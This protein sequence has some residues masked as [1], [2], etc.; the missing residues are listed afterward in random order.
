MH[1]LQRSGLAALLLACALPA[2]G[3][4]Q[5]PLPAGASLGTVGDREG[6]ASIRRADEERWEL[7]G[8][9]SGLQPGDWLK[10]ATRGAN[11]LLLRFGRGEV[12]LGPGAMVE[13]KGMGE[14]KLL[15][16]EIKLAP[17]K[18]ETWRVH[19][20]KEN[21][22]LAFSERG[23]ARALGE[24][25]TRLER[26]PKWLTSYEGNASSEAMG[27]LL[28]K[29]DGR[30][31][32]L[33]MGYH[34]V[35][36]DIRDQIARTVVEESF[37]NHTSSILEGV[38][39]FP[40]PADASISGFSMW[41]GDE[42]VH[43]EIVE[44]QRARAIYETILREKRD[45]GLLEWAGGNVFKAR[46]YPIGHEKRIKISYTQ[47]LPKQGESYRYHY[48][49][50]SEMLRQHPLSK[51]ELSATI[52]SSETLTKV[53]SPSHPGRLQT[54]PKA[55]RFEFSAEETTP[56]RD[57]ELVV[58]T[59]PQEGGRATFIPHQR[60]EDGYFLCLVDAPPAPKRTGPAAP[61]DLIVIADTSGSVEGPARE[62]L[63]G[64]CEALLG[65][66]GPQD[67]FNLLT[68]DTE[69][70]WAFAGPQVP[71]REAIEGA[72]SHV[73]G[74]EPLGWSDLD[75]AFADA[76]KRAQP[77]THIVY[78]GDA[79]NTTGDADP[80]AFAQ[81]AAK[82][83]ASA[84]GRGSVH[85]V[86]PGP[87]GESQA[88]NALARLGAGSA[89]SLGEG[90]PALAAQGLID[91]LSAPKLS[92]LSVNFEGIAVAAL[93]PRQL[94]NLP[95]GG[96]Q[97]L[98]GRFLPSPGQ[99]LTAKVSVS[100]K[101]AG[102][103]FARTTE[104][105]FTT[106]PGDGNSFVPRL[107]ARLHLDALM[108]EGRSAETKKRVIELSEDFQI[109]TPYTSF[110]VLESDEDRER[111][112]VQKRFR[113]RD[114]EGFF[115]QGRSDANY[116]L[117]QKALLEAKRWRLHL[118]AR[119]LER[120]EAM[121]RTLIDLLRP[122]NAS[123]LN[124]AAQGEVLQVADARGAVG[125]SQ[126]AA[127]GAKEGLTRSLSARPGG[128]ADGALS[129]EAAGEPMPADA[130]EREESNSFD[131]DSSD[132]PSPSAA[133]MS[134]PM[135]RQAEFAEKKAERM[136]MALGKSKRSRQVMGGRAPARSN[137]LRGYIGVPGGMS[138]ADAADL[139]RLGFLPVE[140]APPRLTPWAGFLNLFPQVPAR[141][142][143]PSPIQPSWPDEVKQ[144]LFALDR[145]A[146]LARQTNSLQLTIARSRTDQRGRVH[147]GGEGRAVLGPEGWAQ[148]SAHVE[149]DDAAISWA[150]KSGEAL[151]RG[152]LG[153]LWRT[154]ST[155]PAKAE[156][157]ADF[158][159][160]LPWL[161][162][163]HV[164]HYADYEAEIT[165]REPQLV[166]IRMTP[167]AAQRRWGAEVE[168]DLDPTRGLVLAT[169]TLRRGKLL[170]RV[171]YGGFTTL[172]GQVWPTSETHFDE[173]ET[174]TWVT[175]WTL[176]E[177]P[178]AAAAAAR[179]ALVAPRAEGTVVGPLPGLIEARQA[180]ASGKPRFEDR[181]VALALELGEQRWDDAEP[182]VKALLAEVGAAPAQV[183]FQATWLTQ[184][185]RLE[186][187][188]TLIYSEA[189]AL[190]ETPR[191]AEVAR[192]QHLISWSHSL[193]AAELL[194]VLERLRAV[195]ARQTT[196]IDAAYPL[197]SQI[198]Q[199]LDRV[200]RGEDAFGLRRALSERFP[201]VIDAQLQYANQLYARRQLDSALAH[202][203]LRLKDGGPWLPSEA[204]QLRETI[205]NLLWTAVRYRPLI[206]RVKAWDAENLDPPLARH[207][208]ERLL[209]ALIMLDRE[210]EA[211][212]VIASWLA[213]LPADG[214][215]G[216]AATW[217]RAQAAIYHLLGRVPGLYYAD[218]RI[219]RERQAILQTVASR[220]LGAEQAQGPDQHQNPWDLGQEILYDWRFRQHASSSDLVTGL[221]NELAGGL[222]TLPA[223]RLGRLCDWLRGLGY[224]PA[225]NREAQ[226]GLPAAGWP[227]T[228]AAIYARWEQTPAGPDA[229]QLERLIL[230][231]GT[232]DQQLACHR[233][234][235]ELAKT[236]AERRA[237]GA[238]LL[239]A[240]L[241]AAWTA[242][243]EAEVR[244]LFLAQAPDEELKPEALAEARNAWIA[245][246]HDLHTWLI[247]S[248]VEA[249]FQ[250]LPERAQLDRRQVKSRRDALT[251][252]A[253]V[254]LR[255][256]L[257]ADAEG[258]PELLRPWFQIEA[259]WLGAKT[260]QDTGELLS[261]ARALLKTAVAG[262]A[263]VK[264]SPARD[265]R[266]RIL[267]SRAVATQL[268]LL[269]DLPREGELA[270]EAGQALETLINQAMEKKNQLLDWREVLYCYLTVV[271]GDETLRKRLAEWFG[272]GK[273]VKERRWG[274][275]L[276]A[277]LVERDGLAEA[278]AI[279]RKLEDELDHEEWRR[280][281][282]YYTAL[283][284][285]EDARWAK[286]QSWNHL[287]EWRLQQGLQQDFYQR[288]QRRGDRVPETLD[289]EIPL[290]FL[291]VLR[292]STSPQNHVWVLRNYYETTRDFRLLAC[293]PEAALGQSAQGIYQL[294]A[295]FRQVSTL[296]Q[297]EA[298]L[299]QLT[300]HL[301]VL[302]GRAKTVTDRRALDLIDF[303]SALQAARQR[304]GG[305]TSGE[306][307]LAAL[308][309]AYERASWAEGEA[310][311]YAEFL[312]QQGQLSPPALATEQLRQL[313][314]ILAKAD[315]GT[316]LHVALSLN[317]AQTEWNYHQQDAALRTLEACLNGVRPK[318]GAL[319]AFAWSVFETR[320]G[321]L[322]ARRAFREGEQNLIAER[323]RPA[324]ANMANMFEQRLATLYQNCLRAGGEVS[325]GSEE[326]LYR[327]LLTR[328][329]ERLGEAF[330]ENEAYQRLSEITNLLSIRASYRQGRSL[331]GAQRSAAAREVR[332]DA[333]DLA[334]TRLPALLDRFHHRGSPN[335]ISQ[336]SNV[337]EQVAGHLE[338]LSFQ[339]QRAENERRWLRLCRWDAWSNRGYQLI[340]LRY[341][342]DREGA[343]VYKTDLGRR[344][345]A[346]T[347]V[348]L[349][350]FLRDGEQQHQGIYYQNNGH[351]WHAARG[352]FL[353]K[354][355]QIAKDYGERD[356]VLERVCHYLWSGLHERERATALLAER[357]AAGQL[358]RSGRLTLGS[359]LLEL[360]RHAAGIPVFTKLVAERPTEVGSWLN[361]VR[362]YHHTGQAQ[363]ADAA[364]A[365]AIKELKAAEAWGE[366][367]MV[368]VGRVCLE[369]GRYELA[370]EL[371]EDGIKI[372]T[373]GRSD[374]GVGDG[375]LGTYY[376][377]LASARAQMGD[378]IGA[379]D[380]A[381]GAIVA[382]GHHRQQRQELLQV[383][384][385][386]LA[387]A[388]DLAA[389]IKHLD[390]EVAETGLE[391]PLL[392]RTLGDVLCERKDYVGA[393]VQLRLALEAQE[394]DEETHRLAIRCYDAQGNARAAAEQLLAL[395]RVL[396]HEPKV[397]VELGDRFARAKDAAA[398]ERAYTNLV[399]QQP[400]EAAA[401]G[402][403]AEVRERQGRFSDAATHWSQVVRVRSDEPQGYIGL[404]RALL[405]A[406]RSAAEPL[407]ALRTRE[408]EERFDAQVKEALRELELLGRQKSKK[409]F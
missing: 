373:R 247:E 228:L 206:E 390:A 191:Q 300:K 279:L 189:A 136:D 407:E 21:S 50:R 9:R 324:D 365:R 276:A 57:F 151:E 84:G 174:K 264:G 31:V 23:V 184:R 120:L 219:T 185:R 204:A 359:F 402:A 35:Q 361:L 56:E 317:L 69:V 310:R 54:T 368:Q 320:L 284:Q 254:A 211:D 179:A 378:T 351:F 222:S 237:R 405:R 305:E 55:A 67:R 406:G 260:K 208:H 371:L 249:E 364:L 217:S 96:Q 295:G 30:E 71:G 241:G 232:E 105:S 126:F 316:E 53:S 400:N 396:G 2:L 99:A 154:G 15:R 17:A 40:L 346:L 329:Y 235:L 335:M 43:G 212:E 388:K 149:G 393:L 259:I 193:G 73:E 398:A 221:W 13:L 5:G 348:G 312:A 205:G 298:T 130:L 75:P 337:V 37:V 6:S 157:L 263:A 178:P 24:A 143:E 251:S 111:F 277:V 340:N 47:V 322:E 60:A 203:D 79:A 164:R 44:K 153:L 230:S 7:A 408:W 389:Y 236:P 287:D 333:L 328:G 183:L 200:G 301:E 207:H 196:R 116:A 66:L 45:P 91:E 201:F 307:A 141:A 311:Y 173:R 330:D 268:L 8:E 392:R 255:A 87:Q 403:L 166:T 78:V 242:E 334:Y 385:E 137:E 245:Q 3:Q 394:T 70:R 139:A 323:A 18:G 336:V 58:Q 38:F 59:A 41:I 218:G 357:D 108:S 248:R 133:P 159:A 124:L 198:A 227:P 125:N 83:H 315:P 314:A 239:G 363:Q 148:L 353:A 119:T 169:R 81:R 171:E 291:A 215:S 338:A 214:L 360:K 354:S 115:A 344:L 234:L 356:E 252:G 318:G 302:R 372:H 216:D 224:T 63:I 103:P 89:R 32:A 262:V 289:E 128:E 223:E 195:A 28:A 229:S 129:D 82:L 272:D 181:L 160:L 11:A 122:G 294:A 186:E 225:E 150:M 380:A 285:R 112:K 92:E 98:I 147:P 384:R 46:V 278:A 19:G 95:L 39:Y 86:Q 93:Y 20:P 165:L 194:V 243:R 65:S 339:V 102:Q 202:L 90:D 325:L 113:M 209:A 180:V 158:P 313:R 308:R 270:K 36:V 177:L 74:R 342:A 240:L 106:T 321:Y 343:N 386:I 163:D 381:A 404:A 345:L 362:C 51:L 138:G 22:S 275:A 401:Q 167:P 256:R 49:L 187:L 88:I 134:P 142:S 42:Q 347:L 304:Q 176:G 288:Y 64:F 370:A 110:L 146:A 100:A 274:R 161:L 155:R 286:V 409:D 123:Q 303:L 52:S 226:D 213:A 399:E 383:L 135:E 4:E 34:K 250:A 379:V 257:L 197:E 172:L 29:V 376:R 341:E 97:V 296:L 355:L 62:A 326:Q 199:T 132:L 77:N 309:S 327:A 12:T 104:T 269:A 292:K 349:E 162:A 395:A 175:T 80:V 94:P 1:G 265:L 231:Y 290:R 281:A 190:A 283:D 280:L 358:G 152:V 16:G 244:R 233:R 332:P 246:L 210:A 114:G 271:E 182:A 297:E 68:V 131:K 366:G 109:M 140:D 261:A 299:D 144:L 121:N 273:E 319:P 25:L 382:W 352:D 377:D 72:L 145:R 267:A 48:A 306:R 369:T 238:Q 156:D 61:I 391:N 253:R 10:T 387:G 27:S 33:T 117:K 188:R 127:K 375:T 266:W 118:R 14:L 192:S 76:F 258:A 397:Y 282:D 107:W 293:V 101:A 367:A 168:L 331:R 26:D 85:V 374:R 220:L 170:N 350:R